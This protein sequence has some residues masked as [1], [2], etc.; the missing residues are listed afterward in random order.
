MYRHVLVA[1]ELT[2]GEVG[3][4]ILKVGRYLAGAEG[5][6]TV[7]NVV[8]PLPTYIGVEAHAEDLAEHRSE[9]EKRLAELAGDAETLVADGWPAT[10]ILDEA[11]RLGADAI[12]IGSHRPE[13][14]DYLLGS[15]AARVVRHAPC[16]VVVERTVVNS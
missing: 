4:H 2:H 14:T 15:T 1:V 11:K 6:V 8:Q 5:R 13:L 12:V 9:T 16:T 10:V 3:A 7:L